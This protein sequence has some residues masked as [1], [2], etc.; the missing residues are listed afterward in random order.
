MPDATPVETTDAPAGRL[1]RVLGLA[2]ARFFFRWAGFFGFIVS[3]SNCPLCGQAGCPQG[4]ASAGIMAGIV[5]A[6]TC[7]VHRS[8]HP[9]RNAKHLLARRT[10][11]FA[12]SE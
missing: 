7:G 2:W 6:V 8:R 3:A 1:R 11:S 12:P 10:R 5:A 4:I 9:D